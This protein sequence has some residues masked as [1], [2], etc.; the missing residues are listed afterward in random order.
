[1]PLIAIVFG[2]LLTALGVGLY[3]TSELDPK[4]LTALIPCAFGLV[5]VLLGQIARG[6]DKA[7]MHAMHAAAMV[8]LIGFIGGVVMTILDV[9]KLSGET[10]PST[11]AMSGKAALAALC[12]VF[13]ALCI[14]SFIDARRA[15]K[16]RA[17]AGGPAA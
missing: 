2:V 10:P 5:L 14:K 7:R 9:R 3:V 17:S 11:L 4:P 1:V 12:A 13:L 15:R 8:G 16:Q 6:S